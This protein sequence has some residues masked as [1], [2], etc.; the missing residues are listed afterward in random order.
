[1]PSLSVYIEQVSMNTLLFNEILSLFN[2]EFLELKPVTKQEL[3][4]L[5]VSIWILLIVQDL[6]KLQHPCLRQ[7]LQ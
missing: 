5:V 4:N 6:Y 3:Q 7:G 1:M 2:S